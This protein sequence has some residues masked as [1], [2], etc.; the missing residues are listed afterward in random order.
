MKTALLV[1]GCSPER[2]VS[3]MS[4]K[5]VAAALRRLGEAPLIVDPATDR[6]WL[7]TLLSK[8]VGR[9]FNILH[10][11]GGEDGSIRGALDCAGIASTGSG[12]LGSAL[13]MN[14]HISKQ[15]WRFIGV[16]TPDWRLAQSAAAADT[17]AAELGLPLFVKPVSGGSSQHSGV[18]ASLTG[19][20]KAI[21]QAKTA[22]A[23][24]LV[25]KMITG[26]EYTLSV[27]DDKP[28]P[29]IRITAQAGFFDYHAKYIDDG[30]GYLCPCDLPA[31]VEKKIAR[32]GMQAF[33]ALHCK[34]WGRVDLILDDTGAPQFLEANTVPGMTSHS[35]VP[36]A[37]AAAG[38]DFDALVGRIL[39]AAE[40]AA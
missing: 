35:L 22:T 37:A 25:E 10:G 15:I 23:P 18:A 29:L 28:L 34:H 21:R 6:R 31:K 36:M 7:N 32:L 30:T 26:A 3:L 9:V 13:A 1:G 17:I 39:A 38:M 16:P 8:K 14:K 5:Q 20:K 24:A 40:V 12:V 2:E 19:L 4:G 11:G 27:V 33:Q